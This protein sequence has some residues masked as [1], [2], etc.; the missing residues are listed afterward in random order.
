MV[1]RLSALQRPHSPKSFFVNGSLRFARHQYLQRNLGKHF[2]LVPEPNYSRCKLDGSRDAC[3][4]AATENGRDFSQT[5]VSAVRTQ[6]SSR[7][8]G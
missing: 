4:Q 8:H 5:A 1:K 3:R 7:C 2:R 6:S